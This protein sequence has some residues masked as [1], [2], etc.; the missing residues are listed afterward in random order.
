[1]CISISKGN[2]NTDIWYWFDLVPSE[3]SLYTIKYWH[4]YDPVIPS[5][6]KK[7]R[8]LVIFFIQSVYG[9]RLNVLLRRH[10][11]H[12]IKYVCKYFCHYISF[13]THLCSYR[14]T[15]SASHTTILQYCLLVKIRSN[16]SIRTNF[17]LQF[18]PY[19]SGMPYF[20]PSIH[21]HHCFWSCVGLRRWS[22]HNILLQ[23]E[24]TTAYVHIETSICKL[25]WI[26]RLVMDWIRTT[27]N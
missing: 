16:T 5:C 7:L 12:G 6:R 22:E 21:F 15:F 11:F 13:I 24:P 3:K 10:K 14:A 1:M 8:Q 9:S 17:V 4:L 23:L 26:L 20:L 18:Y 27:S 19:A 25:V 2:I